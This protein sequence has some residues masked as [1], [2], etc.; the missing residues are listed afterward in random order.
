MQ[1]TGTV[2]V[3]A[4]SDASVFA[5]SELGEGWSTDKIALDA[6]VGAGPCCVRAEARH[7]CS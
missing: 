3:R 1:E 2:V 4:R 7:R 6:S 5:F